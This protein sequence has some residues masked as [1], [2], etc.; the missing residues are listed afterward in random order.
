MVPDERSSR[1]EESPCRDFG[2]HWR[3]IGYAGAGMARDFRGPCQSPL[4]VVC[5]ECDRRDLWACGNHRASKCVPCAA[6]YRRR[7]TRLASFRDESQGLRYGYFL[8]LTAP[9][10][11]GHKKW[12]P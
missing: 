1:K 5:R 6:I 2:H 4:S 7:V 3:V 12:A 10:E 9:G 8:T 11:N